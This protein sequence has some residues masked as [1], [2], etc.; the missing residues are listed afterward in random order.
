M[1]VTINTDASYSKTHK[2]GTYAFWIICNQ[3]K[4]AKS[5]VLKRK[6][7]RP[8]EAEFQCII[9]A[10]HTL[11]KSKI[12]GVKK[13]IINTDCLNVIHLIRGN[14]S[15]ISYYK[16]GFGKNMVEQFEKILKVNGY[17]KVVLEM[18]HVKAHESTETARQ[19]VNE[20]C[21]QEAKKRLRQ[22]VAEQ[23]IN[24]GE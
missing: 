5:G 7:H 12:T 4:C 11:C 1:I 3:G 15:L 17:E 10:I 9:N 8:E 13:I 24:R 18:R 21:D 23:K 20:W 16:L 19:W 22:A 2:I 14:K 6:C